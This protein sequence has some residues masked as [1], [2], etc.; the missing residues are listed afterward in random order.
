MMVLKEHMEMQI[1][2]MNGCPQY[3]MIQLLMP[4]QFHSSHSTPTGL[5]LFKSNFV[6]ENI[7]HSQILLQTNKK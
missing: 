2:V 5:I 4:Y 6:L 3:N 7:F 1:F